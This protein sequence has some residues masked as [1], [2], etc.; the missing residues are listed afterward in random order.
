MTDV[1]RNQ[2]LV[3]QEPPVGGEVQRYEAAYGARMPVM[4]KGPTGCAA[5]AS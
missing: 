5:M 3:E 2:Y 4:L 1:E